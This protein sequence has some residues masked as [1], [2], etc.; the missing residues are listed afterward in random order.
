MRKKIFIG[1]AAIAVA[2]IAAINVN[3]ALQGNNDLSALSLANVEALA[4]EPDDDTSQYMAKIERTWE[5]VCYHHQGN[6]DTKTVTKFHSV[7]CKGEGSIAC[8]FDY[9]ML[10]HNSS[11]VTCQGLAKHGCSTCY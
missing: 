3:F 4:Q 7:D 11:D 10:S 6:S 2:A 9:M 8:E 5:E 1:I